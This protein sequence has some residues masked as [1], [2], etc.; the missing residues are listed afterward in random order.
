MDE[1]VD[2][3]VSVYAATIDGSPRY[4]VEVI[5]DGTCVAWSEYASKDEAYDEATLWR[6]MFDAL[7]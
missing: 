3:Q 2:S 1:Y 5:V 6:M 7:A 4:A